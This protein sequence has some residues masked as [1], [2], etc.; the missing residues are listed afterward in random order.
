MPHTDDTPTPAAPIDSTASS[1]DEPIHLDYTYRLRFTDHAFALSN[2]HLA[3]LL[4]DHDG[5]CRVLPIVDSGLADADPTLVGSM[6]AYLSSCPDVEMACPPLIVQGGEASKNDMDVFTTVVRA[7]HDHD[8][9]R[10]SVVLVAGG[11]AVL[12]AVGFAA[13]CSHRGVGLIR[14][15]STTVSQGDGGLGVKNGI[16]AM[17]KKNFLGTFDPPRGVL[18]DLQLLTTLSDR[19]HR[20]GFSEAVKV[21]LLKDGAF[22]D[23]IEESVP[24]LFARDDHA[25]ERVIR[26]SAHLHLDH[27]IHGGDPFEQRVARPLDMGH[28]S[29]HR[30]E[31]LSGYE[32][33]HGEAVAIGLALD[34]QYATLV[35]LLDEESLARVL[36]VLAGLG[37]DL[38]HPL[39]QQREPLLD[40]VEEF[41]QH[42]GGQLTITLPSK[43]GGSMDVHEIDG[44]AMDQ[45][46]AL[47]T[48]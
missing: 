37:F 30:L 21:A 28:W 48:R 2:P 4:A 22:F 24:L 12:D 29:A 10:H 32:I 47:L 13:S 44:A 45:A 41:R 8:I 16:N 9:C 7:I 3:D 31:S 11:G 39:L 38:T 6:T 23:E 5:P 15:P 25:T 1:R 42:L 20:C 40:G 34:A 27:I 14:L 19:D 17:G 18:N 36:A 46:I 26:R 33:R 35:G 43:L